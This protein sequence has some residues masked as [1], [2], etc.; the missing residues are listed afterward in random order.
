MPTEEQLERLIMLLDAQKNKTL[1]P[2]TTKKKIVV[3]QTNEGEVPVIE[4]KTKKP[5]KKEIE[6]DKEREIKE[7]MEQYLKPPPKK[8]PQ[9]APEPAQASQEAPEPAPKEQ[10]KS[11]PPAQPIPAEPK[12]SE[13]QSITSIINEIKTTIQPEIDTYKINQINSFIKSYRNRHI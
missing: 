3:E 8:K 2:K 11:Q 12:A 6:A 9:P 13:V 4:K 10:P 1:K 7:K 5:T